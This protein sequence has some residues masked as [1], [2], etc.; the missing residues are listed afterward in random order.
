MHVVHAHA[1]TL[2]SGLP[3]ALDALEDCATPTSG[4]TDRGVQRTEWGTEYH[5]AGTEGGSTMPRQESIWSLCETAQLVRNAEYTTISGGHCTGMIKSSDK[6][7]G[8][9]MLLYSIA[10]LPHYCR[11]AEMFVVAYHI[12]VVNGCCLFRHTSVLACLHSMI[13]SRN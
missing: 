4:P 7:P 6:L 2:G 12:A 13:S 3:A 1:G 5:E 11:S 10:L 8:A 9:G